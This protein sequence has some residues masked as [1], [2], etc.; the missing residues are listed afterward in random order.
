MAQ[1]QGGV[2]SVDLLDRGV[3][4]KVCGRLSSSPDLAAVDLETIDP[5]TNLYE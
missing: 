2:A 1:S 5:E 4:G 3:Q